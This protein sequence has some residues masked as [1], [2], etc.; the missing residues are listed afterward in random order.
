MNHKDTKTPRKT[1]KG[2]KR[3]PLEIERIAT[4]IVDAA[5]SVHSELGPGL[6]ESVY[7]ACLVKELES[8][9]LKVDR[10]VS[11]P[12]VYKGEDIGEKLKLDLLIEDVVICELKAVL[13]MHPVY[14]A[15]LLSYLKLSALRLGFL[16]NFNVELIKDGIARVVL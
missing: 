4:Q 11:V 16:I 15:Q 1:K 7:E 2:F 10:Q 13:E 5:F 12:L 8:R 6:L 14:K 9:G 3:I